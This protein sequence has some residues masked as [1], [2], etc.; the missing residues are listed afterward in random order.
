MH[1]KTPTD[2]LVYI[3]SAFEGPN[4]RSKKFIPE[5]LS[6]EELNE[7]RLKMDHLVDDELIRWLPVALCDSL[8]AHGDSYASDSATSALA[9]FLNPNLDVSV[10][11]FGTELSSNETESRQAII[12]TEKLVTFAKFNH[13][14]AG[15][16]ANWL[17]LAKDWGCNEYFRDDILKALEYW[18]SRAV[19]PRE[20]GR[21]GA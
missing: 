7:L 14:Q 11:R 19:D 5:H 17:S 2:L 15:A 9:T 13:E 21:T 12:N 6:R 4:R 3:E 18:K 20:S 16:I 10:S 1:N 8:L